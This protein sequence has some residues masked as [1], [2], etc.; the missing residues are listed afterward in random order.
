MPKWYVSYKSGCGAT[1]MKIATNKTAYNLLALGVD[2]LEVGS[3]I[4]PRQG[5]VITAAAL[6][7]KFRIGTVP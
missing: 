1:V 5:N 7:D 4:E 6:R 3:L 2:V